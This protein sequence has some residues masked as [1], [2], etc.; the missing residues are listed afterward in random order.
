MI[1]V[2]KSSRTKARGIRETDGRSSRCT[3][4]RS[5]VRIDA[6]FEAHVRAVVVS[7]NRA[8]VVLEELRPRQRILIGVPLGIE[9]EMELFEAS[10]VPPAP[11][12]GC[13]LTI[14][15]RKPSSLKLQQLLYA[16]LNC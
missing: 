13:L 3:R 7:D 15:R 16:G 4:A 9:L 11:R 1:F 2:S 8:G 6:G 12:L 14:P 10:G 5:R